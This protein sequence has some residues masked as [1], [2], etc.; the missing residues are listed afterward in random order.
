L[1]GRGASLAQGSRPGPHSIGPPGLERA[2]FKREIYARRKL[3]CGASPRR[4]RRPS[5]FAQ[6]GERESNRRYSKRTAETQRA[7]GLKP[8]K[9]GNVTRCGTTKVV[10]FRYGQSR[11]VVAPQPGQIRAG[12]DAALRLS[13]R[14]VSESRTAATA[15][16]PQ[17]RRGCRRDMPQAYKPQTY[18]AS[19]R[20][21]ASFE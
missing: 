4:G 14:T 7:Q 21:L 2:D 9:R 5:A 15:S 17:S 19:M 20:Y 18:R 13:L 3:F 11:K 6:D 1:K 10:P 12:G 16:E 8:L